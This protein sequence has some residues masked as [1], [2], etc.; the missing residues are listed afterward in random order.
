[1][2]NFIEETIARLD[3]E[4]VDAGQRFKAPG[5]SV[6][7]DH[8]FLIAG[9]KGAASFYKESVT[10]RGR[11]YLPL[12]K[13]KS[14]YRQRKLPS[15]GYPNP[16]FFHIEISYDNEHGNGYNEF[17][18][19]ISSPDSWSSDEDLIRKVF[20]EFL[21]LL[22]WDGC[23]SQVDEK[24][25]NFVYH[26]NDRDHNGCKK[27]ERKQMLAGGNP[28]TP[29]WRLK[30]LPASIQGKVAGAFKN[31]KP[32]PEGNYSPYHLGEIFCFK[33]GEQPPVPTLVWEPV[34]HSHKDEKTGD[35]EATGKERDV[36]A[37]IACSY[38]H[39]CPIDDLMPLDNAG[40][41]ARYLAVVPDIRKR[42]LTALHEAGIPLTMDDPLWP[43]V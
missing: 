14:V 7:K 1:M 39:D 30:V 32:T 6:V 21:P 29:M 2:S 3:S 20:P 25:G 28:D 37:A 31:D 13:W 36:K 18:I 11:V 15:M 10:N 12:F 27:S 19:G 24:V 43:S 22:K 16:T 35:W 40:L 17:H 23:D 9:V 26:F 41:R 5:T 42:F 8:M 33:D 34:Y 4:R 38:W